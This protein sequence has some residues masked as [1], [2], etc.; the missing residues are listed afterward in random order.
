MKIEDALE[1]AMK[2]ARELKEDRVKA[3]T[4]GTL[5]SADIHGIIEG[6]RG[7]SPV[8]VMMPMRIDRDAALH[9]VRIAATGFGCDVI[10]M[11]TE[12]WHPT[13]DYNLYNPITGERK[14]IEQAR[15]GGGVWG[16]GAMQDAAENH[17]ALEKGWMRAC[18]MTMVVNRAGDIASGT[19]DYQVAHRTTVLGINSSTIEW[20]GE[21]LILSTMKE[22]AQN[23]GVIPEAMVEFMNEEPADVLIQKAGLTPG[24]FGL[25]PQQAQAHT[26]C[27]MVKYVLARSG[28][29]GAVMLAADNEERREIIKRSLG[30]H[31]GF[32]G[33]LGA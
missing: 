25:T 9:A 1:H 29:E 20:V 6:Y 2:R 8:V 15:K 33:G 16:P 10:A 27:A 18:L 5:G 19:V 7:N 21:P 24:L 32:M 26:D 28:F 31:P 22:G 23:S 4:E 17:G 13:E 30:E 11:T 12:S 14:T 3:D